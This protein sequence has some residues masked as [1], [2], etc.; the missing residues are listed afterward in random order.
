M[1]L[2]IKIISSLLL[3]ML[4]VCFNS[5]ILAQPSDYCVSKNNLLFMQKSKLENV[6]AFLSKSGY[7]YSSSSSEQ[8]YV[9]EGYNLT[10]DYIQW[11]RQYYP[12]N[13]HFNLY[14]S[15]GKSSIL[16]FRPDNACFNGLLFAFSKSLK[17]KSIVEYDKFI[18]KFVD[19]NVNIEFSEFNNGEYKILIFDESQLDKDVAEIV[20][21]EEEMKKEQQ[22][23]DAK[24]DTI[25]QEADDFFNTG[26][27]EKAKL[28]YINASELKNS[29]LMNAK[30]E[31]CD[32]KICERKVAK[33]DSFFLIKN[34]E[35]SLSSFNDA[36]KC[37]SEKSVIQKKIITAET[38][39]FNQKITS[40]L[41]QA[42]TEFNK[43]N[44][45]GALLYYKKI[46][47]LD[48]SNGIAVDKIA[49]IESIKLLLDKRS[50]TVFSY[51]A[52]NRSEY[53]RFKDSVSGR[54][55]GYVNSKTN[56]QIKFSYQIRFDTSG[57]NHSEIKVASS[58]IKNADQY[59]N[60]LTKS[61]F[62]K[63][64]SEGGFFLA[65][66]ESQN[67]D[68][69]WNNITYKCKYNYKKMKFGQ[70]LIDENNIISNY[71]SKSDLN[72]GKYT[73]KVQKA[74]L[75]GQNFSNISILNY[76]ARGPFNSIYSLII[77]GKGSKIVSN[78]QI[79]KKRFS[80]FVYSAGL[81]YLAYLYRD[82]QYSRYKSSVTQ[83]DMDKYFLNANISH[84]I[85]LLSAGF[86][87]SV[88][89]YDFV[90]A[91]KRGVKNLKDSKYMRD[92]LNFSP[93]VI[94]SQNITY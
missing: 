2:P 16:D 41:N 37:S 90:W 69:K 29:I 48:K 35:E 75:N 12:S 5:Y 9:H 17:G 24:Y 25:V 1:K 88:Y 73:F 71:L 81:A 94:K 84:K 21:R 61:S 10:Y 91:Y 85:F 36:L 82:D 59:F 50:S 53:S 15:S 68:F 34:Y 58:T 86:G 19:G 87:A 46:I 79:G 51:N 33:G 66:T 43:R 28:L 92:N 67:I 40:L 60:K 72:N 13:N 44:Y 42:N 38:E 23:L 55:S 18:T 52:L 47:E 30:I 62:L 78:G 27:Y 6:R 64:T 3:P 65:S 7:N 14:Y 93:K 54:L 57:N 32:K 49:K 56:G 39:I 83:Q 20:A 22:E 80:L 31:L 77:P 8:T 11:N 63:P 26:L 74:T 4:L 45:N 89:I 70:T 76:R